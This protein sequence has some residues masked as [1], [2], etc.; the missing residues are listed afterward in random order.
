LIDQYNATRDEMV[1]R[2]ST[3]LVLDLQINRPESESR[4][5]SAMVQILVSELATAYS[6]E[7]KLVVIRGS[8]AD[9]CTGTDE[10]SETPG[11]GL[12]L[13][14]Q[15]KNLLDLI[16]HAPFFSIAC[17]HGR[18]FDAGADIAAMCDWR[19]ASPGS[20]ICFAR[21][22]QPDS[23]PSV[24]RLNDIIGGFR[25]F[26]VVVRRSVI[27]AETALNWGL[28]TEVLAVDAF[29]SYLDELSE[30]LQGTGKTSIA[31]LREATRVQDGS[32]DI[33]R[34]VRSSAAVVSR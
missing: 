9:F 24:R 3:P 23:V 34:V 18:A 31:V 13:R 4:L 29:G 20:G 6:D 11:T 30:A 16:A 10:P 28:V 17:L 8:G 7:T 26:D 32:A 33:E 14:L 21:N 5:T 19:L 25:A 22:R 1:V 27:P 15:I 2:R 12:A